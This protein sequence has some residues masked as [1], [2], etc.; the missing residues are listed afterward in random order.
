MCRICVEFGSNR[1]KLCSLAVSYVDLSV[2]TNFCICQTAHQGIVVS[3]IFNKVMEYDR[4][5]QFAACTKWYCEH[6]FTVNDISPYR[7]TEPYAKISV[8]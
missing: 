6:D 1:V 5:L 7:A 8:S 2:V 4:K 3:E